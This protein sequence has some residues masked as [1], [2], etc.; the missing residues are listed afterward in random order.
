MK[1]TLLI[2]GI[3]IMCALTVRVLYVKLNGG[4]TERRWY[5]SHLHYNFSFRVDSVHMLRDN[6]GLG[7]IDCTITRGNP[8]E[9][10]ED[11][12]NHHL[13]HHTSLQFLLPGDGLQR[14]FISMGAEY[15][16]PGDSISVNSFQDIIQV[17]RQGKRIYENELS[18][19]LEARG[20][21]F[22]F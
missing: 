13:S 20:N 15:L 10:V 18:T 8:S 4:M 16:K 21:P 2:V 19:T 7:K 3:L 9:S 11:S 17:Y 22:T 14:A 1:T 6:V 5:T 12:L